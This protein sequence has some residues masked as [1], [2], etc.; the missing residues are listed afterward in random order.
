MAR[1]G[2]TGLTQRGGV[3]HINKIVNGERLY[4]TCGTSDREEA[5]RFLIHRLEQLRQEKVYGVRQVRS[6]RDAAARYLREHMDQPSIGLTAT[7]LQQLDPFIGELPVTHIDDDALRPFV[8]WMQKGGT[9]PDGETVKKPSSNRTINIAL[10]RVVRILNLCA[11]SWRDDNKKPW[12]DSVPLLTMLDEKKAARQPHPLSWEEQRILFAELPEHL[13]AMALFKVNT[14]CREQEVCKLQWQWEI[15]VPELGTSVFLIP[16]DFGG[17]TEKSGVK[18]GEDRVVVLNS[19]AR[20]IITAQR[21]KHKKWVFPYRGDALHRMNDTAWRSARLRAADAWRE[22]YK[23]EP[24][25]G[26]A[27]TRVHDL[28]HTFGR[29]LRAA[30]ISFEDRQALL[31]HKSGSVTTHYSAAEI[32]TLIDAA[33]KV[34]ATDTRAPALTMLRRKVA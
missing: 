4:E 32:Q 25:P 27:Q 22:E 5:E 14:G 34:S 26:L 21:G 15:E 17:R 19:V 24:H 28:K 8:K 10:Q 18:N 29:R 2:I 12:I 9:M 7:Y 20:S 1:K 11:R 30:G 13:K 16:G 6:W 23:S 3:W 33:N 31:G